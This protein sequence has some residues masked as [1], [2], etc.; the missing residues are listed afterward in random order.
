MAGDS[1]GGNMA[2]VLA[3][4]ARDRGGPRLR[5]QGL[6]YPWVGL[7][8]TYPSYTENAQGPGL[9]LD[10]LH[11]FDQAYLTTAAARRDPL[12]KPIL[13]ASFAGLPPAL[14]ATAAL[15]PIRDDGR[16]YAAKLAAAG[17]DVIYR[18]VPGFIHGFLRARLAG[19]TA[20]VE[21]ELLC[22]FLA[23]HLAA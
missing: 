8:Y 10:S 20:K 21:F 16:E 3:L 4:T 18:E 1:A 13:A 23:G 19:P 7:P 11:K 6:V 17:T 5:A 15:D 12:A 14:V 2:A 22:A 9:T